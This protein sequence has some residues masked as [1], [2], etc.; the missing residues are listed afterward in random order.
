MR[1][2]EDAAF[3]MLHHIE[4]RSDDAVIRTKMKRPRHR[5][6]GA[7]QCVRDPVLALDRMGG[8]QQ[9]AE[10]LA[11]Q[12]VVPPRGAESCRSG[13]TDRP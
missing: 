5:K 11:P 10:G 9:L 12:H 3:D 7:G 4:G 1:L 8:R 13:S 6:P 2:P